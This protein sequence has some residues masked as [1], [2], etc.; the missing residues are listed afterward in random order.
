MKKTILTLLFLSFFILGNLFA[1]SV[2]MTKDPVPKLSN[3]VNYSLAID[4]VKIC[5]FQDKIPFVKTVNW[6]HPLVKAAKEPMYKGFRSSLCYGEWKKP[7]GLNDKDWN[8]Y[9]KE[10]ETATKERQAEIDELIKDVSYKNFIIVLLGEHRDYPAMIKKKLEVIA[11]NQPVGPKKNTELGKV[12]KPEN[13]SIWWNLSG[14]GYR[15]LRN[16]MSSMYHHRLAKVDPN[17]SQFN[18]SWK[19]AG[20]TCNRRDNSVYPFTECEMEY[21]FKKYLTTAEGDNFDPAKFDSEVKANCTG[22]P[23]Y[24]YN[25]RGHKNFTPLWLESNSFTWISRAMGDRLNVQTKKGDTVDPSYYQRPF[26]S[27]YAISK[28][29]WGAYLMYPEAH[30]DSMKEASEH[31][32]GPH[33]YISMLT[34]KSGV[35]SLGDNNL[36]LLSDYYLFPTIMG[37]G[38][39]GLESQAL[40]LASILAKNHEGE[41]AIF[42]GD[43]KSSTAAGF[44]KDLFA[45]SP[46][47]GFMST[48]KTFEE[49]MARINVGL[50]R[51]TNWGPTQMVNPVLYTDYGAQ[52]NAIRGAYSPI[53][54]CS[55]MIDA[56]HSF[57]TGDY[58][59]THPY[60]RG[61]TKWMFVQ[62][63]PASWYYNEKDLAAGKP[64]NWDTHFFNETSLSNDYY[65]ERALDRFGWVPPEA[66]DA[67]LYLVEAT[68]YDDGGDDW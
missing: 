45:K 37:E 39:I 19:E 10:Y 55:Y 59:A 42:T 6:D 54:A 12:D 17:P 9:K 47:W 49:R 32:G 26:A 20:H 2:P 56:S 31:G 43:V 44:M 58:P 65:T 15:R 53:V 60:E 33:L 18:Y 35:E 63:L 29:V 8:Y 61:K 64:I 13:G 66:I 16:A 40:P 52:K 7:Y 27:R 34:K 30:H 22:A 57:A 3:E 68:G 11:Y 67:N 48:F 14:E 5:E 46:D 23:R 21:L 24:Y 1:E 4:G 28:S 50:D 38:D 25:F 36:D 51:H 62:K 41:S